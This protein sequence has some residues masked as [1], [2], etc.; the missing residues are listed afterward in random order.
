MYFLMCNNI[1]QSTFPCLF[2]NRKFSSPLAVL[3]DFTKSGHVRK[4]AVEE[5][6]RWH[7]RHQTEK[8][9]LYKGSI[10]S[11][12]EFLFPGTTSREQLVLFR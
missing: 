3:P 4:G 7:Y 1:S 8:L 9:H 11:F 6:N 10:S 5:K 2:E 12:D